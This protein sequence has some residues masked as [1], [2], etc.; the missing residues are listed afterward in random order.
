MACRPPMMP[1]SRPYW[2]VLMDTRVMAA[3][4]FQCSLMP[5]LSSWY[6]LPG[7]GMVAAWGLC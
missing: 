2:K 3:M 6:V 1:K 5:K 7:P 4:T